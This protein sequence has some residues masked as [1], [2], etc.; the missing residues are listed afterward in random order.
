MNFNESEPIG[1]VLP[2]I[3][4]KTPFKELKA[5]SKKKWGSDARKQVATDI[6]Q[7]GKELFPGADWKSILDNIHSMGYST[8]Y[9]GYGAIAFS[10]APHVGGF[11]V[12]IKRLMHDPPIVYLSSR[13]LA[14]RVRASEEFKDFKSKMPY[15]AVEY[16]QKNLPEAQ[17]YME[18]LDFV[19][20][21]NSSN[22]KRDCILK[23]G[24]LL[25]KD[26]IVG[27]YNIMKKFRADSL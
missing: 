9:R 18:I 22:K 25:C 23:L 10:D 1:L 16:G 20:E 17:S 2:I 7:N 21:P 8:L 12:R 4:E 3:S 13:V 27:A 15:S 5:F 19:S 14:N 6:V 26:D 11:A 24:K